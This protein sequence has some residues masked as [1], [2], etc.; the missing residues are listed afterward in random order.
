[1][2]PTL[3]H[4]NTILIEKGHQFSDT[5]DPILQFDAEGKVI[6]QYL[7]IHSVSEKL[8]STPTDVTID[9]E[10]RIQRPIIDYLTIPPRYLDYLS[11]L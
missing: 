9:T 4:G 2:K 1:M 7:L 5:R 8:P 10:F 11:H 6:Y 3:K